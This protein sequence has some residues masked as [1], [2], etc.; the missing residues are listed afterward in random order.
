MPEHDHS[1]LAG[2]PQKIKAG[3]DQ[4]ST[5][6][7]P[8]MAGKH[9]H[10]SQRNRR[11]RGVSGVDKHAAEQNVPH[12][13]LIHLGNQGQQDVPMLPQL[14]GQIGFIGL[15]KSRPVDEADVRQLSCVFGVFAANDRIQ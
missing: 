2:V 14:I 4:A 7:S 1:P 5:N 8:L 12:N 13:L 3:A 15:A 6:P 9:G 11:Y 10:R